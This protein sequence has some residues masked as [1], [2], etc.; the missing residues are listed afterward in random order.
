MTAY[1]ITNKARGGRMILTPE[2][3]TTLFAGESRVLELTDNELK[4][5]QPYFD[6]G[7]F[8]KRTP[9][10]DEAREAGLLIYTGGVGPG[11]VNATPS[12]DGAQT[13]K[14]NSDQ[15]T[16]PV[17]GTDP[18]ATTKANGQQ[19]EGG[20]I[21]LQGTAGD[22]RLPAEDDGVVATHVEHRGFG[23]WFG[24]K[25]SEPVTE[26]M[27][28]SEAEGFANEHRIP[29]G[30]EPDPSDVADETEETPPDEPTDAPD[31]QQ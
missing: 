30:K 21:I 29:M 17:L 28:R 4:A 26:A 22:E 3:G 2:G 15:E 14:G 18:H 24:M 23:R 8:E 1:V 9:S 19:V 20:E 27:T 6:N 16:V 10:E 25:G 11:S 31:N 13:L 5:A 7:D 12:S